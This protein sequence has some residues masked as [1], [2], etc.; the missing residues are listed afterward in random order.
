MA[1]A[2]LGLAYQV[3]ISMSRK[4]VLMHL[5]VTISMNTF[6]RMCCP[7]QCNTHVHDLELVKAMKMAS[8]DQVI[9]AILQPRFRVHGN[10][11][12]VSLKCASRN[13]YMESQPNS[14]FIRFIF[15]KPC[16][17]KVSSTTGQLLR[18]CCT[19]IRHGIANIVDLF[20]H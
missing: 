5:S 12:F 6:L 14:H 11:L 20:F 7:Y 3:C 17:R 19:H 16:L 8:D 1:L 2:S 15:P 4:V 9:S 18:F 10:T 13:M